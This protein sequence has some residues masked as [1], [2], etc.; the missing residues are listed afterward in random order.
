MMYFIGL[1]SPMRR[2]RTID[3][4]RVRAVI[5]TTAVMPVVSA[6][7]PLFFFAR[8]PL[9]S[10]L[11]HAEPFGDVPQRARI[12]R[13]DHDE[14]QSERAEREHRGFGNHAR[15]T[16]HF[17]HRH[18]HAEHEH[19]DHAPRPH[20]LDRAQHG[21]EERRHD[22]RANRDQ[23]IEQREQLGE[24][25]EHGRAEHHDRDDLHL[26]VPQ[27]D[28]GAEQTGLRRDAIGFQFNDRETLRD[29]KRDQRGDRHGRDAV[30]PAR[31]APV[32]HRAASLAARDASASKARFLEQRVALVTGNQMVMFHAGDRESGSDVVVVLVVGVL[33]TITATCAALHAC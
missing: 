1:L 22:A 29:Q 9:A 24:R 21:V 14:H 16:H 26:L 20:E 18:E 6:R 23:K 12:E 28:D 19:F 33:R 15:E 11:Q 32:Q 27:R 8:V 10:R 7:F 3:I 17:H 30:Q 25:E 4:G 2:G 31:C 5:V 13:D